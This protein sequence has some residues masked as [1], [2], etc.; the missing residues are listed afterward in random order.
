[1]WAFQHIF[2]TGLEQSAKAVLE[3]LGLTAAPTVYLVGVLRTDADRHPICIE[4]EDGSLAQADFEGLLVR[5]CELYGLD[6]ASTMFFSLPEH[7]E[8]RQREAREQATSHA[9]CEAIA[10]KDDGGVA[11]FAG[12]PATVDVYSVYPVIVLPT[13]GAARLV[14]VLGAAPPRW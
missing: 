12:Y 13:D 2:R 9:I 4:P 5:A 7:A 6:P 8:A 11:C 3:E 1:M 10:A 14:L